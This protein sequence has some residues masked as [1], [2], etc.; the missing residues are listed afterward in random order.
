MAQRPYIEADLAGLKREELVSLIRKQ[1]DRFPHPPGKL[2]KINIADMKS[3]LLEPLAGFTIESEDA[4]QPE[5]VVP[6][7]SSPPDTGAPDELPSNE[8]VLGSGTEHDTPHGFQEFAPHLANIVI[9]NRNRLDLAV[10][11]PRALKRE[12]ERT[13]SPDPALAFQSLLQPDTVSSSPAATRVR[14]APAAAIAWLREQIQMR[15]G[16]ETFRSNQGKVL[17]NVDRVEYWRF[18]ADV[19]GTYF[20]TAWPAD[21][22][23]FKITKSAIEK[24]LDIGSTTLSEA[25]NMIKIVETYT[26]GQYQSVE[27]VEEVN[28]TGESPAPGA[29]ALKTFLQMWEKEHPISRA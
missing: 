22:A 24:G 13:P 14:R 17:Q 12:R 2:S 27:V 7:R 5:E 3:L 23:S 21:I 6:S 8:P 25:I 1:L 15:P 4:A 11:R 18:A 16:F 28:K 26:K 10:H 19:S 9:P 29:G 20:R